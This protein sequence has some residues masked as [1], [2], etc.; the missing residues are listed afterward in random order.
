MLLRSPV[1]EFQKND[2][3]EEDEETIFNKSLVPRLFGG[4]IVIIQSASLRVEDLEKVK[5]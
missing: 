4:T 1:S 3:F 5:K 2:N